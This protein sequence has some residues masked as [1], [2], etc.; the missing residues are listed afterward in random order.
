MGQ[1]ETFKYKDQDGHTWM[2]NTPK[3]IKEAE[4]HPNLTR[5]YEESYRDQDGHTWKVNTLKGI[6]EAE[7]HPNLINIKEPHPEL[8]EI[9]KVEEEREEEEY[10]GTLGTAGAAATGA[11]RGLTFG[12]SDVALP[13]VRG[14]RG[15]VEGMID[16]EE[17]MGEGFDRGVKVGK[18]VLSKMIEHNPVVSASSE[19]AGAVVPL[20]ATGGSSAALSAGAAAKG[21]GPVLARALGKALQK[22][23]VKESKS[24]ARKLAGKVAGAAVEAAPYGLTAPISAAALEEEAELTAEGFLVDVGLSAVIGAGIGAASK[25]VSAFGSLVAKHPGKVLDLGA[26]IVTM[27]KSSLATSAARLGIKALSETNVLKMK[28]SSFGDWSKKAAQG[29][30]NLT[31]KAVKKSG[32]TAGATAGLGIRTY[33]SFER[34][35]KIN[36]M[37]ISKG[38]D[39][40]QRWQSEINMLATD[41]SALEERL[42]KSIASI[43]DVMPETA[44]QMKVRSRAAVAFMKE[45]AIDLGSV[46]ILDPHRKRKPGAIERRK[47]ERY[48]A[49]TM[50]PKLVFEEIGN[51]IVTNEGIETLTRVYPGLYSKLKENIMI[52]I[53]DPKTKMNWETK[54]KVSKILMLGGNNTMKIQAAYSRPEEQPGEKPKKAKKPNNKA[55]KT[56]KESEMTQA[57]KISQPK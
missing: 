20:L 48:F 7:A 55:I 47:Y 50:Q 56:M 49:Y 18:H 17:T 37:K 2:V 10:G 33:E 22:G 28:I 16:P 43:K 32:T 31:K 44:R 14:A 29:L 45:K 25:G 34:E 53:N 38:E 5:V 52:Q 27:G 54:A 1:P 4:A 19:I 8:A 36:Q 24:T 42:E 13:Y 9:G 57:Q 30:F 40:H 26:G 11:L 23:I 3:G 51:G 6:K 15:A 12:L 21:G 35:A 39:P 41:P 46:N